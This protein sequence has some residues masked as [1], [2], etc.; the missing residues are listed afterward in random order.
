[1]KLFEKCVAGAMVGLLAFAPG[2]LAELTPKADAAIVCYLGDVDQ[3]GKVEP[4]DARSI[5]RAA[6]GLDLLDGQNKDG[7]INVPDSLPLN[8]AIIGD[9]DGDRRITPSDARSA[10]RIAVELDG[11]IAIND[12]DEN[13][14]T[15][16]KVKDFV[17]TR[18]YLAKGYDN[19]YFYA[20]GKSVVL[21]TKQDVDE[22]MI[23]FY[24]VIL[25]NQMNS[26][27]NSSLHDLSRMIKEYTGDN[28]ADV[29]MRISTPSGIIVFEK[30]I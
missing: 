6:V 19:M 30:H 5:L 17:T 11:R 13:T 18:S 2:F 3:N 20:E 27:D 22:D 10:L 8:Q 21:E 16:E 26:I 23:E 28:S 25:E 15:E 14:T 7:S 9:V 1:M 12:W 29:I 4:S 24:R